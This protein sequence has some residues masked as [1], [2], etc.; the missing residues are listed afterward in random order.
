MQNGRDAGRL[1]EPNQCEIH[2][3]L[4]RDASLPFGGVHIFEVE[5]NWRARRFYPNHQQ[6]LLQSCLLVFFLLFLAILPTGETGSVQAAVLVARALDLRFLV[7]LV[8]DELPQFFR[9]F[10]LP[11]AKVTKGAPPCP[12]LPPSKVFPL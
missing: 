8:R 5:P 6:L 1:L 2:F 9:L 7:R 10:M 4:F 12:E 11:P 3:T